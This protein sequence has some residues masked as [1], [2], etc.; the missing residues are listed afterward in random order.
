MDY[1]NLV[2]LSVS[3]MFLCLYLRYINSDI[4]LEKLKSGD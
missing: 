4:T 3:M 1:I 2:S